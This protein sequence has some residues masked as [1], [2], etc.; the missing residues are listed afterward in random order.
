MRHV[1][2]VLAVVITLWLAPPAVAQTLS[3]D[4]L[5][6]ALQ[7]GGYVLVMARQCPTR[8]ADQRV[9][10]PRQSQDGAATRRR[11]SSHRDGDGSGA[12]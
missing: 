5:V 3:G 12:A 7:R 6:P 2:H 9:G 8:G 4:A 11:W 10:E 1:P